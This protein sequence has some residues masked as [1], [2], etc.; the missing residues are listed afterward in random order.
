VGKVHKGFMRTRSD[1]RLR[2]RPA[3]L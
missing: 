1:A 2:P 3:S